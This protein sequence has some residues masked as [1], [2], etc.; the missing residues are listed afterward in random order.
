MTTNCW[1]DKI[2]E[3]DVDLHLA[4]GLGLHGAELTCRWTDTGVG[5]LL[6]EACRVILSLLRFSSANGCAAPG[7]ATVAM[8]TVFPIDKRRACFELGWVPVLRGS[9]FEQS[10]LITPTNSR[11]VVK[12]N[13]T[14]PFEGRLPAPL[15]ADVDFLYKVQA[16]QD[17]CDIIQSSHFS[18]RQE[19][20]A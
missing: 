6:K 17:V 12:F 7:R 18:C 9:Q 2:L 10:S 19:K 13:W 1:A 14:E 5:V 16:G 8:P 3:D 11:R 4:S 20:D 15:L